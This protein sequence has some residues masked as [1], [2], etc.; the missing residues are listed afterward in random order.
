M[1]CKRAIIRSDPEVV[2][3][4]LYDF[5]RSR[6][7]AI[8]PTTT[9]SEPGPKKSAKKIEDGGEFGSK[10]LDAAAGAALK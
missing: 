2:Q 7:A 10:R 9:P 4:S 6:A 8:A 5:D 1:R 3:T